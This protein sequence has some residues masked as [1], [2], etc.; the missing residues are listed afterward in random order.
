LLLAG[1]DVKAERVTGTSSELQRISMKFTSNARRKE[2]KKKNP[3]RSFSALSK[4][5][6]MQNTGMRCELLR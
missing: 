5:Q 2:K 4:R 3:I 6:E 1:K